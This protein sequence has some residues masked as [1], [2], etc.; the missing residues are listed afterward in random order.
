MV[1]IVAQGW[2]LNYEMLFY[3]LFALA[4]CF[5]RGVP[6]LGLMLV[7]LAASPV[8]Y[9]AD[10]RI[11]RFWSVPIILEFLSGMILA[12]LYLANVRLPAFAALGAFAL[13]VVAYRHGDRLGFDMLGRAGR[14]GVP[15]LLLCAGAVLIPQPQRVGRW[16]RGVAFGGDASYALY[17]AHYLIINAVILGCKRLSLEWPWCGVALAVTMSGVV[18]LLFHICSNVR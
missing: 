3:L 5:R 2:T 13:A 15:A 8:L 1:P 12:R 10:W 7:A 16:W 4:L 11:E 18:A 14:L 17:L 9:P 6:L